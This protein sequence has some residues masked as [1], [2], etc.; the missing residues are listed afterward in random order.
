[1]L[2]VDHHPTNPRFGTVNLCDDDAAATVVLV[3][4]LLDR[5]GVPL[6]LELAAPLYTG[7]VTD[8]G[9]FRYR[10][11]TPQVH[12]LAARLL[13]TG[14][15]H[16]LIARSLWDSS[17]LA[18]V[19]LLG[20]VCARAQVDA[21]AASGLGMVWT[22]VDTDD[23]ARAG[24]AVGDVEGVIDV[25]RTAREAEVAVVLKQDGELW[26]V[27]TRSRGAIDVGAVCA[28]L[29]GGGHRFAAGFT[30]TLDEA[31]TLGSLRAALDAAPAP[32]TVTGPQAAA[33]PE[34]LPVV[35][36]TLPMW[37]AAIA[38]RIPPTAAVAVGWIVL[39]VVGTLQEPFSCT[40]AAP[41]RPDWYGSAAVGLGLALLV[42]C[43]WQP[44]WALA[45]GVPFG[46]LLLTD[47]AFAPPGVSPGARPGSAGGHRGPQPAGGP[48][49]GRTARRGRAA[50]RGRPARALARARA[51]A[52]RRLAQ[53]GGRAAPRA[54]V[55]PDHLRR[56][57]QPG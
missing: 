7:L 1:V 42:W 51:G 9:S 34:G 39:V 8:T 55:G 50:R 56:A 25:V 33:L 31:G 38:P 30:S 12:E 44:R 35:R 14:L 36:A 17:S 28:S 23:L 20:R 49:A 53:P 3:A 43:F 45:A 46:L 15:R 18:Y 5:L 57:R 6:T 52:G 26:K 40:D 48:A 19:Q 4:E 16:D 37:R 21:A 22:C 24:L 27:S 47:A 32:A 11:T 10:A 2:V 54:R 29:G 41:C 13:A